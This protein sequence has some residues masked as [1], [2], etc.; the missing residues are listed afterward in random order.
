MGEYNATNTANI[1]GF[2]GKR[3]NNVDLTD[4]NWCLLQPHLFYFVEGPKGKVSS[5]ITESEAKDYA[6][7]AVKVICFSNVCSI[8]QYHL[9]DITFI[10]NLHLWSFYIIVVRAHFYWRYTHL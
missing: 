4:L 6:R 8:L 1:F 2:D 3:F 9:I 7:F 10:L 5:T